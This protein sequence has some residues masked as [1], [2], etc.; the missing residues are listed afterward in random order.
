MIDYYSNTDM[1]E[2]NRQKVYNMEGFKEGA[3]VML[4]LPTKYGYSNTWWEVKFIDND[5]TF[6]GRL[7][8]FDK[9]EFDTYKEGEDVSFNIDQVQRVY[10]KGEHFCYSDNVTICECAGLCRN[11]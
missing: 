5:K 7:F 11:K 3:L 9:T 4:R 2:N 1:E 8:R 6:I 10:K